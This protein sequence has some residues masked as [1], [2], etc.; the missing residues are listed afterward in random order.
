[1][2][3]EQLRGRGPATR[4]EARH[5][6]VRRFGNPAGPEGGVPRHVDLRAASRRSRR[7]SASRG[8]V[9]AQEPRLH[10]RWPCCR[11]RSASAANA[12]M[13][14]LVNAV[15]LRPLPYPAAERLVRLTGFYPKGAVVAAA[16][17]EPHAWTSPASSADEEFNLTGQGEA[18]RLVGQH[19]LR[20]PLRGARR[21]RRRWAA[22]F[23]AGDDRPGRDRI[24]VL[25]HALWQSRFGGDPAT[26]GRTITVEGVERQVVGVMPPGLP[27]PV[28]IGAAL[29]PAAARPEPDRG[30]LG[31]RLDAASWPG[32]ARARPSRR[33]SDEL[34]AM[35]APDR[36][37]VPVAGPEL[38]RRRRGRSRCRRTSCA[39][40]AA[41][42]SCCRP[43]SGSCC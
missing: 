43:R 24:V 23:E 29:G 9:L 21:A 13:F 7:T 34:R 40:S 11:S 14:S 6:A 33:R 10:R 25:S 8:R 20:E 4:D 32:S 3:E 17:A 41:S 30:L 15:L 28:G 35:I 16:G 42:C 39:T 38:E 2:R 22:T 27:L 36:R 12:A 37:A 5:A 19:G 31:L 1:M 26:V 18:V